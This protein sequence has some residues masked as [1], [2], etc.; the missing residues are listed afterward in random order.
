M[1]ISYNRPPDIAWSLIGAGAAWL[2]DDAGAA[3][4]NGRPAAASRLQWLSG[5]Q[6]T[7]SVLTLRGSWGTA[8]APRVVGLVGLTLPAGTLIRL[9]FRRPADAGYTYL[10]DVPQQRIVQLPDG[11]RC[12]WFV[13]DDG[14]DPVI[15]VEYRIVNDV[16]G[17]A[18][19]AAGAV[20]DIG[21]AW[22]GPTV[23][24]PH[25]SDWK[26][27]DNDPSTTRRSKGSQPFTAEVRG[28]RTLQVPF[29]LAKRD[30]VRGG[31][32]AN[33]ADWQLVRAA[34]R[35][36]NRLVAVPRFDT[37]AEIQRTAVFGVARF[38]A[39]GHMQG[40]DYLG[41]ITVD[42]APATAAA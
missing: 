29:A 25:T 7:A 28:Y 37:A 23:E 26:D 24:I 22:V 5:A 34:I 19:I 2:S 35:A 42:E 32:L 14:L 8:I 11:S 21:E 33:G 10:A 17:S 12:A 9:A 41:G 4:I 6:T 30:A 36:G 1:L 16:Y 39:I 18:S 27:L 3:L 40:P 31:G 13:L 38:D 15:G 20:V